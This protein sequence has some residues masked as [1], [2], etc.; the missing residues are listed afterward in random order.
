M[1]RTS[2]KLE[3]K[4]AEL[5]AK[6]A[7]LAAEQAKLEV[8]TAKLDFIKRRADF[9]LHRMIDLK[10]DNIHRFVADRGAYKL[11]KDNVRSILTADI[12]V[13]TKKFNM[14]V[15]AVSDI[16]QSA[17]LNMKIEQYIKACVE[18]RTHLSTKEIT[19]LMKELYMTQSIIKLLLFVRNN[20]KKPNSS[21]GLDHVDESLFPNTIKYATSTKFACLY[22]P[23]GPLDMATT[24]HAFV[25]NNGF[26]RANSTILA[27]LA[28]LNR[29][30]V[31]VKDG[32]QDAARITLTHLEFVQ[33]TIYENVVVDI[34]NIL[35]DDKRVNYSINFIFQIFSDMFMANIDT[36]V[37]NAIHQSFASGGDP[38]LARVSVT[39]AIFFLSDFRGFSSVLFDDPDFRTYMRFSDALLGSND[40][41]KNQSMLKDD[42]KKQAF[43]SHSYLVCCRIKVALDKLYPSPDKNSFQLLE[44]FSSMSREY[45]YHYAV[46]IRLLEAATPEEAR[47]LRDLFMASLDMDLPEKA[48]AKLSF[49]INNTRPKTFVEWIRVFSELAEDPHLATANEQSA[50]A[51]AHGLAAESML[52]RL[53]DMVDDKNAGFI[54][55]II[56]TINA[57]LLRWHES[58]SEEMN[59]YMDL[60]YAGGLL[61]LES[62]L[63]FCSERNDILLQIKR[64]VSEI[65]VLAN[66]TRS[67][68][69]FEGFALFLIRFIFQMVDEIHDATKDLT[70]NSSTQGTS[71][72][73]FSEIKKD[74]IKHIDKFKYD[75]SLFDEFYGKFFELLFVL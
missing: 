7:E 9:H 62:T 18:E 10:V 12:D 11:T 31:T 3:A 6:K 60:V 33:R 34:R 5:E 27:Q 46:S 47:E 67:H 22:E 61:S 40:D 15:A 64:L 8:D 37:R 53:T 66:A 45:L 70:K 25:I 28:D 36:D 74:V 19:F 69:L 39:R 21:W 57:D 13:E 24:L 16:M 38:N 23:R 54:P 29:S 52:E 50:V 51:S 58:S 68:H 41:T 44:C 26:V 63:I 55:S 20:K 17:T 32:I 56:N 14:S 2:K 48:Q 65:N 73:P 72:I 43:M 4:Q 75:G 49:V 30:F 35:E 42:M 59:T 1:K 71:E